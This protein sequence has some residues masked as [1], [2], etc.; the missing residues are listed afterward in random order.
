MA[1]TKLTHPD[2]RQDGLQQQ[3]GCVRGKLGNEDGR[4]LMAFLRE[5]SAV[6]HRECVLHSRANLYQQR[7]P[8]N[9]RT[10]AGS[11]VQQVR[12]IIKRIISVHLTK[13]AYSSLGMFQILREDCMEFPPPVS[14]LVGHELG[15]ATQQE[16]TR[17]RRSWRRKMRRRRRQDI[18][19]T[20]SGDPVSHG[21]YSPELGLRLW[22]PALPRPFLFL[23]GLYPPFK[24]QQANPPKKFTHQ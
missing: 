6:P 2:P 11:C 16:I 20:E 4:E 5:K 18:G 1:L 24:A 8:G 19:G 17:K 12:S 10:E 14:G 23:V 13:G 7:G 9:S 21:R 22:H 3:P 15:T